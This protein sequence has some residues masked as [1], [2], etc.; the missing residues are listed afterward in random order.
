MTKEFAPKYKRNEHGWVIFP[1]DAGYRK[2]VFP[3]E[4][5]DH[6]A[7]A[8]SFLVE[9][10]IE[11]VSDLDDR[12]MDVMA[13]TGTILLGALMGRRV[14]C[15]DISEKYCNLAR[16]GLAAME[17]LAPGISSQ[18]MIINA[19]CQS[20]LPLPEH[21]HIIFSPQYANIMKSKGTDKL[22]KEKYGDISEYS[23][24]PL[25]LG[26]MNEFLWGQAMEL[27][28]R[29]CYDS[30]VVGG[31]MTLIIKDHMRDRRR[32]PLTQRAVK[33]CEDIGFAL[34]EW[35]KWDAPGSVYTSIYRARG[36]EVVEDEDIVIL[37]KSN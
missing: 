20:V 28:Y 32:V 30:L 12:I 15:V 9:A 18:C 34:S 6:P 16:A 26:V 8:N 10:I 19:P 2:D 31:T 21:N 33:S 35:Y 23:Q 1:S 27:V 36:W 29:K 11:Y 25:N 13:G 3:P 4:V 24:H 5:S 14:T 7:K 22:T 37:G 17:K